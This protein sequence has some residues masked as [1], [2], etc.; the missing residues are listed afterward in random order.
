MHLLIKVYPTFGT[1]MN[2]KKRLAKP[3]TPTPL[4]A[5]LA[6]SKVLRKTMR[7]NKYTKFSRT[8]EEQS[9]HKHQFLF[10]ATLPGRAPI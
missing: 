1:D 7:K 2:T 5:G 4:T 3:K 9:R 8:Y 10:I 6:H